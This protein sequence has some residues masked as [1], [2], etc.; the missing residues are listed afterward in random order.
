MKYKKLRQKCKK[1]L[2]A[3]NVKEIVVGY[4]ECIKVKHLTVYLHK[5]EP[6][7]AEG[8]YATSLYGYFAYKEMKKSDMDHH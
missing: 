4:Y 3:G 5:G 2:E 1:E 8:E 7:V 6:I